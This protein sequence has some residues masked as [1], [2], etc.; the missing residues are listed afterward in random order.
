[1]VAL[2]NAESSLLLSI[3]YINFIK[4]RIAALNSPSAALSEHG[5]F[6]HKPI[7]KV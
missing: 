4:K 5:G 7:S 2:M 6:P 1:M 3:S